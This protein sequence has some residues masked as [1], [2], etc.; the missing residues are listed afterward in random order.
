MVARLSPAARS[1]TFTM[2]EATL[3]A[4]KAVERGASPLGKASSR[5]AGQPMLTELAELMHQHRGML[6]V[7]QGGWWGRRRQPRRLEIADVHA[8]L[9]KHHDTV[10]QDLHWAGEHLSAALAQLSRVTA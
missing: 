9:V 3:L 4:E 2:I 8:G 1:R 7:A 10:L 5:D 6:E